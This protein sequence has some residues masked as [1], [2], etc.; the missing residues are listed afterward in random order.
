MTFMSETK[1]T[2]KCP[3]CSEQIQDNMQHG[4]TSHRDN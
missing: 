4:G 2:E 1:T 3:A